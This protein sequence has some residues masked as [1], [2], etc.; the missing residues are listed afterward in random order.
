MI[1]HSVVKNVVT[2]CLY[3][4]NINIYFIMSSLF[5]FESFGS[6]KFCIILF[7]DRQIFYE[8]YL[9]SFVLRLYNVNN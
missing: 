8:A 2:H 5:G 3:F 4:F 6:P 7:A 9:A 1:L